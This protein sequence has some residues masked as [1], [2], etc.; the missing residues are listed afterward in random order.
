MSVLPKEVLVLGSYPRLA[1]RPQRRRLLGE[2]E[3]CM[4]SG[5]ILICV[6]EKLLECQVGQFSGRIRETRQNSYDGQVSER[7]STALNTIVFQGESS[8]PI[9][10]M[11]VS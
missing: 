11:L 3:S 6:S 7:G 1:R 9:S 10:I 2:S 5:D 8:T 4:L